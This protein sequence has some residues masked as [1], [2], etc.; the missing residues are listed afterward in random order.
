MHYGVVIM[1]RMNRSS[2]KWHPSITVFQHLYL[3]LST[4][5][6]LNRWGMIFYD[7]NSQLPAEQER[8][9][10]C[11][12]PM[13]T[14]IRQQIQRTGRAVLNMTRMALAS[15]FIAS[16]SMSIGIIRQIKNIPEISEPAQVLN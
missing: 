1:N 2:G 10:K 12:V 7:R 16:V 14:F 3:L 9:C 4:T 5:L 8:L 6:L 11:G 13:I 15:M